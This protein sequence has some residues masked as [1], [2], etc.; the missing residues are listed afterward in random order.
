M[1]QYATNYFDSMT[2]ELD[3]DFPLGDGRAETEAMAV[4]PYC[5]ELVSISID[6]GGGEMQKYVEDC[7]VCCNPWTVTVRYS[8]GVAD[9]NLEPLDD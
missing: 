2:D 6:P 5:A 9:V 1:Y 3:E 7:E 8:G 4:C